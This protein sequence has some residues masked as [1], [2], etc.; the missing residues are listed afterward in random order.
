ML[1]SRQTT[2]TDYDWLRA[3]TMLSVRGLVPLDIQNCEDAWTTDFF[4]NP[5]AVEAVRQ[6]PGYD[7]YVAAL[8]GLLN[9]PLTLYR[10]TTM[11]NYEQWATG[12]RRGPVGMTASLPIAMAYKDAI[13][14]R[15]KQLVIFKVIVTDPEA[16]VMR[17]RIQGYE[18]VVDPGRLKRTDVAVVY[19]PSP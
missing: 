11:A 8:R 9:F 17:G 18:I 14:D 6:A 4:G 19:P 7:R 13:S 3:Y 16:I 1:H 2:T 10:V 5:K 15:E 12:T